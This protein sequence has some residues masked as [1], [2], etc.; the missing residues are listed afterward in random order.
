MTRKVLGIDVASAKWSSNGSATIEFDDSKGIFTQVVAG[1][2][3]WPTTKLTSE[4]LADAIDEFARRDGVCA[5]S[6]DGP[7]GWRDPATDPQTP[8]VGRRC[9][10]LCRTQGKTGSY[11]RTYPGNQRQ[12]IEFSIEVF[13][14]LLAKPGVALA[15]S[16]TWEAPAAYAVLECFPTSAWRSSG[17]AP[18][19]GKNSKPQ[20]E[21]YVSSL[22]AAYRLPASSIATHDDLQAVVAALTGVGVVGGPAS[23]VPQGIP[24][25]IVSDPHGSRRVE[26]FIWNV[27]PLAGGIVAPTVRPT[28]SADSA[29]ASATTVYVTQGVVD[30]VNRA[31]ASQMQIAL[32]NVPGGS[33][34][35]RIR[36]LLNVGDA[37][38]VLVVGDTHA[39]WRSHQDS[40]SEDAFE[41]LFALLA[42]NPG[43]RMPISTIRV[44]G[45]G[46]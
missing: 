16:A 44:V 12:W 43:Q 6:L 5:V 13:A 26:G 33:R 31:G 11:P 37:D 38:Y 2:I 4:A 34:G 21:E 3:S 28:P 45:K 25:T 29:P 9:E 10:Y 19:P 27:T 14:H 30:Q 1:A 42:D 7:Q 46:G 23:A 36:V 8:G 17:L 35:D 40:D 20:L 39:A 24:S 18:L 32:S 15:N 41:R 22:E